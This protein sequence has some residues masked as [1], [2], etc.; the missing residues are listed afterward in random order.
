MIPNQGLIPDATSNDS[1]PCTP[2]KS[3]VTMLMLAILCLYWGVLFYATHMPM[4]AGM[5]PGNSDKFIHFLAY[6]G[7]GVLLMAFRATTGT[8]SWKTVLVCWLV[9]TAFGAFDELT[10]LLVNR[11]ADVYDWLFDVSGSG[12]GLLIVALT[13]WCLSP[14][15]RQSF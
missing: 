12:T 10:Q 15:L 6:F 8:V 14:K 4:P 7:L 11:H 3:V 1:L 5:M 2:W 13:Q 9:I